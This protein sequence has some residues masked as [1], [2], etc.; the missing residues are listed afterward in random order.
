[1]HAHCKNK[2]KDTKKTEKTKSCSS[3]IS[4]ITTIYI[5]VCVYTA[6]YTAFIINDIL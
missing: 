1:M 4:N 5:W 2:T 3:C 6:L